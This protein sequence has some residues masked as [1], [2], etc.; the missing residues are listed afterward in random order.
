MVHMEIS[1]N[2]WLISL[3]CTEITPRAMA[4]RAT[5]LLCGK[6]KTSGVSDPALKPM[7]NT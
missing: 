7:D 2:H 4:L 3:S 5:P 1:P 6:Y